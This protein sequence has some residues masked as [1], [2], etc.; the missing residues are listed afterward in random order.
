MSADHE[1]RTAPLGL[2]VL[3]SLKEALDKAAQ[4]DR[5]SVASKAEL[6]LTDWLRE[7]GYLERK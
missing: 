2:R 5:R 3:P 1:K 6:I 7:K 4:D